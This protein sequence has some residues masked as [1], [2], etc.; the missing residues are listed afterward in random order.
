MIDRFP[1]E[2]NFQ[3]DLLKEYTRVIYGVKM[4]SFYLAN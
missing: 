2:R 1:T 3:G 4:V